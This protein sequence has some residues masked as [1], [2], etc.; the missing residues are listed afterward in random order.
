MHI[1]AIDRFSLPS[2][3]YL[4]S[5]VPYV[6]RKNSVFDLDQPRI[7]LSGIKVLSRIET[8][9]GIPGNPIPVWRA[10]TAIKERL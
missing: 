7:I 9:P 3:P 2:P 6:Y 5:S 8:I 10:Q 1:I 4:F